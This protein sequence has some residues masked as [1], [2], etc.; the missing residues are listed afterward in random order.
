MKRLHDSGMIMSG[1][2]N[3]VAGEKSRILTPSEVVNS[4]PR[5][6]SIADVHAQQLQQAS[7]LRIDVLLIKLRPRG[8]C[9]W[10]LQMAPDLR[11][12]ERTR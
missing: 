3:A 2:V 6:A 8:L 5:A 10:H 7:P 4:T 12:S 1:V 9:S 11:L